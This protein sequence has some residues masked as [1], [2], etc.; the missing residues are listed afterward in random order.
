MKAIFNMRRAPATGA[1]W[2]LSCGPDAPTRLYAT[3][4]EDS[5]SRAHDPARQTH[6]TS[7]DKPS[8]R[9][10]RCGA[11]RPT[12][13]PAPPP[14][15]LRAT[16]FLRCGAAAALALGVGRVV[17]ERPVEV[18]VVGVAL[19][20]EEVLEHLAQVRV[21]GL[22]GELERAAVVEIR[23]KLARVAAAED[24]DGRR[25]LLLGNHVVLLL[26]GRSLE[27][28]PGQRAA[29]EVHE[30]VA[31]RL[32]VVPPALLD[33]EMRVDG[34][35]PRR[36]GQVL[37]LAV[38]DV[39]VRLG[40]AVLFREP[41]VDAV[42]QVGLAAEPDQVVVGLDVAVDEGLV[43]NVLDPLQQ[44]VGNH[45]DRLEVELP[46]T[47]VEEILQRRT[48]QVHHHHVVIPLDGEG[49]DGRDA[50][51]AA[52]NLV[53]LRLVQQLRV[54][55]LDRLQ[56]D[57]HF[58]AGRDV[59]AEVDVSE[60]SRADLAAEPVLVGHPNLHGCHG[61]SAPGPEAAGSGCGKSW[62]RRLAG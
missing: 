50:H 28:L 2:I 15:S 53:Q 46:V 7:Q 39:L 5:L 19:A 4:S 17:F 25:H 32:E 60:A 43:V 51:A 9:G 54:L 48:E 6:S 37:V 44:L 27:P 11:L 20:E 13:A 31:E 59:R 34:R 26:L 18:V 29:Q 58:L 22:V 40:V 38:R 56:L 47:E 36:A 62:V 45:E 49:A 3:E 10:R 33:A 61:S 8:L 21:V 23:A 14:S 30:H 52:Q 41:K 35:V 55:A 57:R 24:L 12:A 42:D 1:R 16:L